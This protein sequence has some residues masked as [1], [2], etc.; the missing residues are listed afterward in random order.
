VVSDVGLDTGTA[1]GRLAARTLVTVGNAERRKLEERTRAAVGAP[2]ERKR[3][4]G[5]PAVADKPSLQ[6]RIAEMRASGMTLQAIADT[7]NEE[8]V[9]TLRGGAKWRPSSVQAAAGYKRPRRPAKPTPGKP[10]ANG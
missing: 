3:R 4:P 7:L 8:N 5:R 10:P 2:R 9:P 1:E 6:R